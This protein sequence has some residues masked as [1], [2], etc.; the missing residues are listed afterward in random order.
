MEKRRKRPH[1]FSYTGL[2]VRCSNIQPC[3]KEEGCRIRKPKVP[4]NIKDK[5]AS[6]QKPRDRVKKKKKKRVARKVDRSNQTSRLPTGDC[7][8]R[9]EFWD[10]KCSISLT[11]PPID[12]AWLKVGPLP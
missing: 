4:D 8:H 1:C 9:R 10:R 12:L 3:G 11:T 6:K 7:T 5:Q 2:E